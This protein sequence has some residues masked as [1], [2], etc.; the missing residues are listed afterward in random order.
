MSVFSNV[1]KPQGLEPLQFPTK[2]RSH[3]DSVTVYNTYRQTFPTV[4]FAGMFGH[5]QDAALLEYEDR[6]QIQAAPTVSF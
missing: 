1:I 5:G 3:S 4:V 2:F 6:E